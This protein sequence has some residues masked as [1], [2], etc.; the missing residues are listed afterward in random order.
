[1]L[2][3][4]TVLDIRD[5]FGPDDFIRLVLEWNGDNGQYGGNRIDG[6]E[7]DG[8]HNV[9]YEQGNLSLEFC[10]YPS[11]QILAARFEKRMEEGVVWDTD[12]VVDFDSRMMAVRLDQSFKQDGTIDRHEFS[13][14][15][16][17]S[18]P[19]RDGWLADDGDLPVLR[20]PTEIDADRLSVITDVM[21]GVKSY[22]LP[23]VFV[24]KRAD[25]TDPVDVNLLASRLK[26]VAHV[27]VQASADTHEAIR[28]S[29][30][31]RR[32]LTYGAVEVIYPK[33][34]S[35]TVRYECRRE[36][37][38]DERQF[39]KVTSAVYNFFNK[40]KVSPLLTWY[41]VGNAA[42]EELWHISADRLESAQSDLADV[43]QENEQLYIDAD[44]EIEKYKSRIAA[45]LVESDRMQREID[46]LRRRLDED[47]PALLTFGNET[48][49][50]PGEIKDIVLSC[51]SDYLNS[52][53]DK[54]S[55]IRRVDVIKDIVEANDYQDLASD[56]REE[57][58]RILTGY[59]TMTPKIRSELK[60][61]GFTVEEGGKH[62]KLTYGGDG[63][64][65]CIL[66]ASG[67]DWRGGSNSASQFAKKL[68]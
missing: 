22:K 33:P 66:P 19:I 63:R 64:Y 36:T 42:R 28:D 44:A 24:F 14:P 46:G 32:K 51:L 45:L 25:G 54:G 20:T 16:F 31:G 65:V 49:M 13:P 47:R 29:V 67:S 56:L 52:R 18:Y 68:F 48:D 12:Y 3:F 9:R 57:L 1:M 15:H 53:S 5:G 27:L 34:V 59:T 40:R 2:V 17:I 30:N 50:F 37:G 21:N 11:G 26:G 61:L 38:Y 41:G 10:E 43:R 58:Q 35:D 39:S 62:Y 7:W 8:S 23:V 60:A 6:I 4:S 55:A